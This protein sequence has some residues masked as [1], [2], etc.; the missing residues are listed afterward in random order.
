[1]GWS[2]V[3][4][5]TLSREWSYTAATPSSLFRLR[6]QAFNGELPLPRM[7]ALIAQYDASL[8]TL[9]TVRRVFFKTDL[10]DQYELIQPPNFSDRRL[11][12]RLAG[13]RYQTNVKWI[14][15]IDQWM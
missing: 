2:T 8:K 11:A 4:A 12:M 5:I 9:T 6:H 10:N 15:T 1:M 13:R 7:Y 3:G 14:T